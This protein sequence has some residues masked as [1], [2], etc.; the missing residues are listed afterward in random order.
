MSKI[1]EIPLMETT[2][3]DNGKIYFHISEN[4]KRIEF[5]SNQFYQNKDKNINNILG[6]KYYHELVNIITFIIAINLPI[7][8]FNKSYQWKLT[9]LHCLKNLHNLFLEKVHL[10]LNDVY[11][12]TINITFIFRDYTYIDLKLNKPDKEKIINMI[13]HN[14]WFVKREI[15]SQKV[16][17]QK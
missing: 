17:T 9:H 5:I 6:D 14:H 4:S 16:L 3:S 8:N 11:T 10:S 13:L 15:L 2:I 7:H 1:L 12:I